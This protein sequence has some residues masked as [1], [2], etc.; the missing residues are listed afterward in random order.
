[1][2]IRTTFNQNEIEIAA[3]KEGL[4]YLSD[5]CLK[6]SN[7]SESE[8]MTPANHYHLLEGF[9][10]LEKGSISTVILYDIDLEKA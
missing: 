6:L 1:M 8:A 10:N 5:I 2:K 9:R 4:K 3:D 7:L